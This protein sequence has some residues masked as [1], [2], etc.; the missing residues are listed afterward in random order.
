[1]LLD[2]FKTGLLCLK[3]MKLYVNVYQTQLQSYSI[4]EI[5]WEIFFITAQKRKTLRN[6]FCVTTI[7]IAY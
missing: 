2:S 5:S 1:M 7:E 4:L 6:R 3:G